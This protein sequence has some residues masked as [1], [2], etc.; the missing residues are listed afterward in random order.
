[1]LHALGKEDEKRG[2]GEGGNC[3]E[4]DAGRGMGKKDAMS[5]AL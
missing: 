4:R 1:M 3:E 2:W 5:F